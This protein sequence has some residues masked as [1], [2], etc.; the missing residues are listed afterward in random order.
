MVEKIQYHLPLSIVLQFL[1]TLGNYSIYYEGLGTKD[2]L[3]YVLK[4][5]LA[6]VITLTIMMI[7]VQYICTYVVVFLINKNNIVLN[8]L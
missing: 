4:N 8:Q 1:I 3:E 5:R 7:I 2:H 6:P